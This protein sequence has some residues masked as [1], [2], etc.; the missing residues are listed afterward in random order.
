MSV[1]Y[2]SDIGCNLAD[3]TSACCSF[4]MNFTAVTI[5]PSH[6]FA[7]PLQDLQPALYWVKFTDGIDGM[8][9]AVRTVM[10]AGGRLTRGLPGRSTPTWWPSVGR[11]RVGRRLLHHHEPATPQMR[12]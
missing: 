10:L 11:M 8:A 12:H 5:E 1:I 7:F 4:R 9:R 2:L 3:D 6:A